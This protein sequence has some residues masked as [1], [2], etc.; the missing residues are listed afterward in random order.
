MNYNIVTLYGYTASCVAEMP[1]H[2]PHTATPM[3]THQP[4][5]VPSLLTSPQTNQQHVNPGTQSQSGSALW[6]G[7][8]IHRDFSPS[9]RVALRAVDTRI[10][11]SLYFSS[12]PPHLAP[13]RNSERA[14]PSLPT[15]QS[16]C[17]TVPTPR[18]QVQHA[19]GLRQAVDRV[20]GP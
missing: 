5:Q 2:K 3:T 11:S 18:T 15:P 19:A 8:W 10:T 14:C 13:R 4:S 7:S 9:L 16:H 20:G 12:Y 17:S 6:P 1:C